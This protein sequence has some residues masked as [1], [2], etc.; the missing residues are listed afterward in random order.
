MAK[1]KG[2]F[3]L[4][5]LVSII[6]CIFLGPLL[7]I[8]QRIMDKKIVATL[9]RF[10]LGWNLIWFLDLIWLIIKGDIF[11][12]INCQFEITAINKRGTSEV[13]FLFAVIQKKSRPDMYCR[14]L[15]Y[16]QI[17]SKSLSKSALLK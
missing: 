12:I 11:K 1:G 5:T 2:Y 4:G 17:K 9:L 15:I 14:V 13:P 8:I 7:G 16:L 6:L 10:F 3:G